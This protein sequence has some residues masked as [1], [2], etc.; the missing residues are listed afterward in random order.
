MR[1]T[2]ATMAR[3]RW[4]AVWANVSG[5]Q[6]D[7]GPGLGHGIGSKPAAMLPAIRATVPS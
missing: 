1:F 6:G 7:A 4:T 3:A 2:S 5:V